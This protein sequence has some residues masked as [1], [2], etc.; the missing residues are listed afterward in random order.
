M[1]GIVCRARHLHGA[2]VF[3]DI[4]RESASDFATSE[5]SRPQNRHLNR[6]RDVYPYD[7]SRVRL[8]GLDAT[9]Y[10]NASLVKVSC[11]GQHSF[12]YFGACPTLFCTVKPGQRSV[13]PRFRENDSSVVPSSVGL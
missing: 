8:D 2:L 5:A 3:Q 4:K 10:I 11:S 1:G 12:S 13:L 7:H 6:Y 9:D